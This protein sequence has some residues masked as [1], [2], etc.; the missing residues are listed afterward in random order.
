M[1]VKYRDKSMQQLY[2]ERQA[3]REDQ[4]DRDLDVIAD[5]LVMMG[6]QRLRNGR[7]HGPRRG[8]HADEDDESVEDDFFLS[9]IAD[10][11]ASLLGEGG[12]SLFE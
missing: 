8:G 2:E 7:G 10:Y 11:I 1:D 9:P 5:M 4:L 6:L 3:N 12:P